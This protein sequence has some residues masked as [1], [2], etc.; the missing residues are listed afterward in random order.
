[1][2]TSLGI[3]EDMEIPDQL[4]NHFL[5]P[6]RVVV[7]YLSLSEPLFQSLQYHVLAWVLFYQQWSLGQGLDE[8]YLGEDSKKQRTREGEQR[9]GEKKTTSVLPG[10]R[11]VARSV[12][13]SGC[14]SFGGPRFSF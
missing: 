8:I 4:P 1:M 11:E 2:M 6:S 3:S 10:A 13:K 12:G 5:L 9:Q 14:C 7:K